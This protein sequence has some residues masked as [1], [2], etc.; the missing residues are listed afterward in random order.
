[1]GNHGRDIIM[2]LHVCK[3]K[4]GNL[5][6]NLTLLSSSDDRKNTATYWKK[7]IFSQILISMIK[8]ATQLTEQHS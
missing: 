2:R 4:I 5:D 3:I 7:T 1:F 6:L 8:N